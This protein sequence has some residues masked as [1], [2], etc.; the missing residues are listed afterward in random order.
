MGVLGGII[1]I[2]IGLRI[3]FEHLGIII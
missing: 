2:V 3:L 1:L